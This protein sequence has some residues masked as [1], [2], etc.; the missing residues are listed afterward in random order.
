M[1]PCPVL[2]VLERWRGPHRRGG[3]GDAGCALPP[4]KR[5]LPS[6]SV[7]RKGWLLFPPPGLFLTA[8]HF[9]EPV[10]PT[11]ALIPALGQCPDSTAPPQGG[12]RA[13]LGAR[14]T[15]PDSLIPE[16]RSVLRL[17]WPHFGAWGRDLVWTAAGPATDGPGTAP[18][19]SHLPLPQQR[20]PQGQCVS[21]CRVSAQ[22][23][24]REGDCHPLL[25]GCSSGGT[26]RS[27]P[28]R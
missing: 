1:G 9:P 8:Q 7:R 17:L 12:C 10:P 20:S 19:A 13:G 3:N 11:Q 26:C 22:G 23:C 15:A 6:W 24:C 14:E 27:S 21:C 16:A 4:W 18:Q 25:C 28:Q 5:P 2:Q